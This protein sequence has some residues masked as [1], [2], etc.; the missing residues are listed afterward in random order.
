[1]ETPKLDIKKLRDMKIEHLK[2]K[3]S[4]EVSEFEELRKSDKLLVFD[5]RSEGEF[6]EFHIVGA[7]NT[8][9]LDNDARAVVGTIYKQQSQSEAIEAGWEFFEE[10]ASKI[11]DHA[12]AIID[13]P[14][15][16][17]KQIVVYCARGGMRSGIVTNI[18]QYLGFETYRLTG[19]MKSY[20]NHLT[21]ELDNL[22]ESFKGRFIVLE[23]QTGTKKTFVIEKSKLPKIDLEDLAQHR[24]STYGGVN[25]KPRS[26][27]MFT[28][29]LYEEF[30][31]IHSE[32]YIIIEGESHRIGNVFIPHTFFE[33][34]KKGIFVSVVASIETRIQ[35][36]ID[37]YF[38]NE[39]SLREIIALTS[40]LTKY[41][42]KK[43]VDWLVDLFNTNKK[44]EAVKFLLEDYYDNVYKNFNPDDEYAFEINTDNLEMAVSELELFIKK[45]N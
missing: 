43:R 3:Y 22:I 10:M 38:I 23:G 28:F 16:K 2:P 27:K 21:S 5:A 18:L 40:R 36:I 41:L 8:P 12:T 34:M 11:V 1:M 19:G 13:L 42:G 39:D 17:D 4:I 30:R 7:H 37:S 9:L 6:E 14:E 32:K 25:L 20:K 29:L 15:N 24:A 45:L 44:E 33:H 26:Q 31:K 35:N